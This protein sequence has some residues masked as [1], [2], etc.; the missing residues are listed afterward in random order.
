MNRIY[1][2]SSYQQEAETFV[3]VAKIIDGKTAIAVDELLFHPNGGGQPNDCGT[4]E[5]LGQEYPVTDLI[6]EKGTIYAVLDKRIA[7]HE[8][9]GYGEPVMCRIDW[10]K[11]YQY[12]RLH[13][14]A[15]LLMASLR[16]NVVN[17]APRGICINPDGSDCMVRFTADADVRHAQIGEAEEMARAAISRNAAVSQRSFP[18]IDLA[19]NEYGSLFRI[20]PDLAFKGRVR[21]VVIDGVDANPCGG[22]HVGRLEE[23]N[24]VVTERLVRDDEGRNVLRFRLQS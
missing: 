23:L 12:M 9:I 16:R 4:I 19:R 14:A 20:D 6:R 13:T 21:I 11:R 7:S 15:H 1:L 8:D 17:F 24:G 2:E 5:L 22:T 18:N 10:T 3:E